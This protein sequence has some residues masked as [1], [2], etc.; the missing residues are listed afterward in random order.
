M[1]SEFHFFRDYPNFSSRAMKAGDIYIAT[2]WCIYALENDKFKR[3]RVAHF[4]MHDPTHGSPLRPIGSSSCPPRQKTEA[5]TYLAAEGS[6]LFSKN[7]R[8]RSPLCCHSR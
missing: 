5:E 6:L 4:R 7:G 8:H 2:N 3:I 1:Y